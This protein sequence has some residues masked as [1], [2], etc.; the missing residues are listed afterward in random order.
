MR[1]AP[2]VTLAVLATLAI[3]IGANTA[4]FSVVNAVLIKPLAY[5]DADRLISVSLAFPVMR[6]DDLESARPAHEV[7]VSGIRTPVREQP[8]YLRRLRHADR[9]S[10]V[11]TLP[12]ADTGAAA[13][14][15]AVAQGIDRL[16]ARV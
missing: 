7:S 12:R 10:H 13:A 15:M 11:S 8:G 5:P 2:V 6:I 3:S 4:I 9:A 14:G 16:Y 1:R